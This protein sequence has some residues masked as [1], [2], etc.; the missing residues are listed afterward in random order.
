MTA[1]SWVPAFQDSTDHSRLMHKRKAA[2]KAEEGFR[3]MD[4]EDPYAAAARRGQL[5]LTREL[6]FLER[7]KARLRSRES[8]SDFLKCLNLYAQDIISR[9][10]LV[11]LVSDIFGRA[12][13]L[14]SQFHSFVNNCEVMHDPLHSI[15]HV[16]LAEPVPQLCEQLRGHG[17]G[18]AG[19]GRRLG[20]ARHATHV[21]P[22][23]AQSEAA[24]GQVHDQA[25]Q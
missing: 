19:A 5:P 14:V 18:R 10:E 11:H 6:Q 24:E 25:A 17:Y 12:P 13:D 8:Y 7:V 2:R 21:Q 4:E 23:H 1:V 3:R 15:L 16:T 22:R 9:Q 20:T